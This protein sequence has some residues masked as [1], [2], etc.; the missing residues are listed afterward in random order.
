[1]TS[2]PYLGMLHT[3]LPLDRENVLREWIGEELDRDAEIERAAQDARE[4]GIGILRGGK[5]VD[6]ADFYA[7]PDDATLDSEFNKDRT[8][9]DGSEVG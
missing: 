7:V 6:P 2:R 4:G 1:M 3:G 9:K 5:R 8:G